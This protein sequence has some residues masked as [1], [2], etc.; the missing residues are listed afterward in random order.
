MT[1]TSRSANGTWSLV[2][3]GSEE[4]ESPHEAIVREL[5]EETGLVLDVVTPFT[6]AETPGP[7]VTE[8]RIQVFVAPRWAGE[9][10]GDDR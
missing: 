1:P 3:G 5:R 6:W 2:G 4:G 8:K 7:C 10:H 9:R